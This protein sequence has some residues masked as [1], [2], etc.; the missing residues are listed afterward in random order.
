MWWGEWLQQRGGSNSQTEKNYIIG[1]LG[2]IIM[3]K[4]LKGIDERNTQHAS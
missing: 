4:K 3:K 1:D 2:N